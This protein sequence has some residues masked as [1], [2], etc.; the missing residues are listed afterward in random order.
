R[1]SGPVSLTSSLGLSLAGAQQGSSTY[2]FQNRTIV[3]SGSA[4]LVADIS[5]AS[6]LG[7][8]V[9]DLVGEMDRGDLRYSGGLF[10]APGLDLT[11]RRRILGGGVGTQFDTRADRDSLRATPLVL[12][13]SQ[14]ARVEYLIDGRLV[15][16]RSYDAG[17]N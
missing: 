3:A 11:G 1:P 6:R 4:R 16:S 10:W 14:P 13:L 2:N 7:F 17:N 5:Y 12:F 9:D 8:V 15:G